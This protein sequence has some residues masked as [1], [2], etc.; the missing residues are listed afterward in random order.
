MKR[1]SRKERDNLT[2]TE[3]KGSGASQLASMS[4]TEFILVRRLRVWWK[5]RDTQVNTESLHSMANVWHNSRK[6]TWKLMPFGMAGSQCRSWDSKWGWNGLASAPDRRLK[7]ER[8]PL[9]SGKKTPGNNWGA[10][11]LRITYGD[12]QPAG[13][14]PLKNIWI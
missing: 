9:D 3:A 11:A 6:C 2:A 7:L 14:A 13:L 8:S 5:A 4:G 1:G 12:K 10:R